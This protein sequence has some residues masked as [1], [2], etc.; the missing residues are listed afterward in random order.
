MNYNCASTEF[1]TCALVMMVPNPKSC[2]NCY[3]YSEHDDNYGRCL[4][5]SKIIYDPVNTI[6]A[7]PIVLGKFVCA[8]HRE[9][10][11]Y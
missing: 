7:Q 8:N 1:D 3:F 9:G 6:N 4:D 11:W 10:T 2:R 5:E